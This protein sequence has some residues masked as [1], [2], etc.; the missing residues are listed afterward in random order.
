MV[1]QKNVSQNTLKT[2]RDTFVQL[3]S[4]MNEKKHIKSNKLKIDDFSFDV[5]NEFLQWLEETKKISASTR[6]NRLA[7]IKSFFRYVSYREPRYIKI[8]SS[9]LEIPKQ[10]ENKIPMNY[11]TI[12]GY[13]ELLHVFDKKCKTDLRGLCI[14]TLLYESGARVSELC[15]I[16]LCDL[17]LEKP[18]T[19]VLFGKGRK[20]RRVPI[21]YSVAAIIKE[22]IQKYDVQKED[23]LFFNAR[24]EKL[25]RE[26][27]N[28]ILQKY[29]K[30]AKNINPSIFPDK[31]SPHCIRHSRAM[32]LLE[33][34]VNLI[35]IRDLLGHSSVTTTEIYSKAN[36]EIKRKH[37][38]KAAIQMEINDNYS[39]EDKDKLEIW[40]K[41]NI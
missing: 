30:T 11:L 5:V 7:A 39:V 22:Y 16:K 6:N 37:I 9:I 35:Y 21:D 8:C 25:T 17:N 38:E 3:L 34:G 14:I 2:Y 33:N 10:T 19:V 12:E 40:L 24:K 28:Y 4:F 36:P 13:K 27:I 23:Y 1:S 20:M 18:C 15:N 29:F 41:N 31:I 26:G 32:H